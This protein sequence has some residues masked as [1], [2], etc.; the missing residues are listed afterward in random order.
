MS[1]N[2]SVI[3]AT[4]NGSKYIVKQLDSILNQTMPPDEI[5]V[6]DD[7]STDETVLLLKAYLH[8]NRIK[9]FVNDKRLGVVNNF[10][11]AATL[12]KR[13][14]WLAFAD[15]DD[16][17]V[18]HKLGKLATEMGVIDDGITPSL[19]YSDLAVIDK[20][21]TVTSL[22]FWDKQ[23][24]R[25]GKINFAT[26]LYGNVVLGCTMIINYP[27]A[28]EFFLFDH[29]DYF[30]D[31]WLGLIAYS[32][33]KAKIL[34]ETL[35]LYRQH[36]SNVTFSEDYKTLGV[37]DG[38]REDLNYILGKKKFLSRQFDLAKAFLL[39]YQNRLNAKQ[40]TIIEN[41]INQENKNYI[42]QRVN[43]RITYC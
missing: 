11:K 8:D 40:I 36:E 19:V 29:P 5:I 33:G 16:I 34:N 32:F 2:I 10:K 23:K 25:P 20:N 6:C 42:L 41:F 3:L 31:E 14:N 30:H 4:Y 43:R 27:M 1:R 9:L 37:M 21:D 17:W 12:A 18:P 39:K 13:H 26:L 35:V 15:Q 22:S 7:N 24:I 38:L 28:K